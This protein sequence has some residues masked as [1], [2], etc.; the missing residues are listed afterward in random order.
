ML[1]Q[2]ASACRALGS[3]LYGD[4]LIHAADDVLAGGPTADVLA[5]HMA[6][7]IASAMPLRMLAGAHARPVRFMEVATG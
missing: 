6:A 3:T 1:R 4:L 2:Q 5:G 7:R